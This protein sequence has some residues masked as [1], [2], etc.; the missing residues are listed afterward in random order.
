MVK[1]S[2]CEQKGREF[3]APVVHHLSPVE[4]VD[5]NLTETNRLEESVNQ[6]LEM[7]NE[8]D[9]QL[10]ADWSNRNIAFAA[11]FTECPSDSEVQFQSHSRQPSTV[12]EVSSVL[13]NNT[14]NALAPRMQSSEEP[15]DNP[16]SRSE[17]ENS[18]G[19]RV[20]VHSSADVIL[21]RMEKTYNRFLKHVL[22]LKQFLSPGE[23]TGLSR[24]ASDAT[25]RK[26]PAYVT[27]KSAVER[28]NLPKEEITHFSLRKKDQK[29]KPDALPLSSVVFYQPMMA[30]KLNRAIPIPIPSPS[31]LICSAVSLITFSACACSGFGL[32]K[33]AWLYASSVNDAPVLVNFSVFTIWGSAWLV[34]NRI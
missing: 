28:S 29:V 25:D 12:S 16:C 33:Q 9:Y 22:S 21:G 2:D 6:K 13:A 5:K 23:S 31:F 1:A 19:D 8:L 32:K 15:H 34:S 18:M 4:E 3:D 11:F 20:P 27:Q 30:K 10:F 14:W 17:S 24:S 26:S 7:I